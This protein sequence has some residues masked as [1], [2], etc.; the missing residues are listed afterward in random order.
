M[1]NPSQQSER[2]QQLL[3][4][5]DRLL[6]EYE[7]KYDLSE[8]YDGHADTSSAADMHTDDTEVYDGQNMTDI[9]TDDTDDT[10]LSAAADDDDDDDDNDDDTYEVSSDTSEADNMQFTRERDGNIEWLEWVN[11]GER[12][13][14]LREQGYN[15]AADDNEDDE[16]DEDDEL[17]SFREEIYISTSDTDTDDD[18]ASSNKWEAAPAA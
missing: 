3:N 11:S 5:I 2:K 18:D 9:H 13:R 16:D 14:Y 4:R 8:V 1:T 12:E 17:Q 15:D 10:D 7:E 6:S